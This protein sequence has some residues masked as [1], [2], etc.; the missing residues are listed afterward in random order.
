MS[1]KKPE[2]LA[3]YWTI[4]G[5]VYPG[6][7]TEVSPFSL[8]ARAEAAGNAGWTGM[9]LVHADLQANVARLGHAGMRRVLEDSGIEHV[10]VEFLADWFVDPADPRRKASD[11]VRRDLLE[12]AAE[13]G[14]RNLKV[15]GAMFDESPPDIPMLQ[16]AFAGLCEQARAIG[17]NVIIEMMPFTNIRNIDDAVAIVAGANQPN[18]GLLIDVWH[19]ARGGMSYSEIAKIP[20]RYLMGVELDDAA[21]RVV[22]TLF[23]DTRFQRLLCG[24][25]AFD[26]PAFLKAIHAAGFDAPYHGVEIISETFRRQS[27]DV[28]ARTAYDTAIRQFEIAAA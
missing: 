27:L 19:V 8:Q 15:C 12:S 23:E 10:E 20:A 14:A 3:A 21:A 1:T 18:G 16:D 13:L 7:P 17:T 26:V 22:G 24:E 9:G 2:L 6:A 11:Q 4:A 5:D 25:G 28:M